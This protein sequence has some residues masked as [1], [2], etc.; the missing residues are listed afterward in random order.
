MMLPQSAAVVGSLGEQ[1]DPVLARFS[2]ELPPEQ[3]AIQSAQFANNK[4]PNGRNF[5]VAF[6]GLLPKLYAAFDGST[7]LGKRG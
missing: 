3:A 6:I 4:R 1:P 2:G 7:R 5:P